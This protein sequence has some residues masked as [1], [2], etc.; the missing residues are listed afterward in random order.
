[1]AAEGGRGSGA[2]DVGP[3][4]KESRGQG[5]AAG[6]THNSFSSPCKEVEVRVS[7]IHT[8]KTCK[9]GGDSGKM[10]KKEEGKETRVEKARALYRWRKGNPSAFHLNPTL[11]ATSLAV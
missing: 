8:H 3:G 2:R 10:R 1:M 6:I 4:R 9:L 5:G 7:F 11:L